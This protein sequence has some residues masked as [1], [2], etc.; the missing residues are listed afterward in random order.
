MLPTS[1]VFGSVENAKC[2]LLR[3]GHYVEQE[4][5][6]YAHISIIDVDYMLLHRIVQLDYTIWLFTILMIMTKKIVNKD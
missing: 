1:V 3:I 6:V 5:L 2:E 4:L